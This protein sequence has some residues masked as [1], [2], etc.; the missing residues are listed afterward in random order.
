MSHRDTVAALIFLGCG[1]HFKAVEGNSLLADSNLCQV[2]PD[3]AIE[4]V[5]VHAE[6]PRGIPETNESRRRELGRWV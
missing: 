5:L 4:A 1:I 3:V 2:R 6:V